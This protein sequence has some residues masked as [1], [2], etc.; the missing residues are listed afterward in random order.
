VAFDSEGKITLNYHQILSTIRTLLK[1]ISIFNF[2][3]QRREQVL[4]V[5]SKLFVESSRFFFAVINQKS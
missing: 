3:E 4:K 2:N 5:A 1:L